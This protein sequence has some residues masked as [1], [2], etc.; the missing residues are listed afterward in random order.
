[1]RNTGCPYIYVLD[2]LPYAH[3]EIFVDASSSW[4]I[5]GFHGTQYF[6][7]PNHDLRIFQDVHRNYCQKSRKQGRPGSLHIAY[8][9]L[10]A[11]MIGIVCFVPDCSGCIVRLNSDNMDVVA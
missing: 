4:G 7:F 1:M 3:E 9:E 11:A 2:Q 10:L 6:A 5:G 8:M